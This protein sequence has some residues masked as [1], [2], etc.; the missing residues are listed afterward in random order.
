MGRRKL[1]TSNRER[2]P[3]QDEEEEC[4]TM[5]ESLQD[6]T[7]Y[8]RISDSLQIPCLAVDNSCDG[9][10]AMNQTLKEIL[11]FVHKNLYREKNRLTSECVLKMSY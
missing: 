6:E 4:K 9:K 11:S 10:E 2:L 7:F 8:K 5:F 1:Y 3:F